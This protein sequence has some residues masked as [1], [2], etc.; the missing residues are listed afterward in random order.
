MLQQRS[1]P[2]T[3]P[4]TDKCRSVSPFHEVLTVVN[5]KYIMFW[6]V[7]PCSLVEFYQLVEERAAL[8][9]RME[10]YAERAALPAL[11]FDPEV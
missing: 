3:S 7:T 11:L 8:I 6:D 5:M 1:K 10:E 2:T 9:F 4:N